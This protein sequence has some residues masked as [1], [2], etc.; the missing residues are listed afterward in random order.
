MEK[1]VQTFGNILH[2]TLQNKTGRGHI[3][4]YATAL[5][6]FFIPLSVTALW[7]FASQR[8]RPRSCVH[9]ARDTPT[10]WSAAV[11]ARFLFIPSATLPLSI[12]HTAVHQQG[13]K[14]KLTC[15]RRQPERVA[16]RKSARWLTKPVNSFHLH[17]CGHLLQWG[18]GAA[19]CYS[20]LDR[21][22]KQMVKTGKVFTWIRSQISN[23]RPFGRIVETDTSGMTDQTS[24]HIPVRRRRRLA[25]RPQL[26]PVQV[27]LLHHLNAFCVAKDTENTFPE[28]C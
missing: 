26:V 2:L 1:K 19:S 8:L 24:F 10:R 14:T 18:R 11:Y 9:C 21:R 4:P 12:G 6:L 23:N 15:F 25:A 28:T 7:L 22:Q 3:S 20:S 27:F 17:K 13:T 5:V 16:L